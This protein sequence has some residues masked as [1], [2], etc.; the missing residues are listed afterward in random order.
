M[1]TLLVIDGGIDAITELSERLEKIKSV[2]VTYIVLIVDLCASLLSCSNLFVLVITN[3][4]SVAKQC[5]VGKVIPELVTS[6]P[7]LEACHHVENAEVDGALV[8]VQ[9]VLDVLQKFSL[10]VSEE[11]LVR[12]QVIDFC[13]IFHLDGMAN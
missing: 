13:P 4:V 2:Y 9:L 7:A 5:E 11:F 1:L 12:L 3:H 10:V 8:E 6:A